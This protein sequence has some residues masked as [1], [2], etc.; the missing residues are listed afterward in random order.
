MLVADVKIGDVLNIDNE[1]YYVVEYSHVTN[2]NVGVVLATLK[3]VVSLV[4]SN[5]TF[6]IDTNVEKVEL[7]TKDYLYSYTEGEVVYFTDV[8]TKDIFKVD[9][10]NVVD[11]LTPSSVDTPYTFTF[12][13]DKLISITPPTY[14]DKLTQDE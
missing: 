6:P 1:L 10:K 2:G 11:M 12:A 9:R 14:L 13:S 3:N 7:V 5:H 4:E 8:N